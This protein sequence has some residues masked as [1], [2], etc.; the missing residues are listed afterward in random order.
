MPVICD[1][2]MAWDHFHGK[3]TGSFLFCY[4][5]FSNSSVYHSTCCFK[6]LRQ[7]ESVLTR[8]SSLYVCPVKEVQGVGLQILVH[9]FTQFLLL[10]F[11]EQCILN[12]IVIAV[13]A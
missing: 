6:T 8:N 3:G 1:G 5:F 7:T 13:E 10:Y 12:T 9:G 4:L 11:C 2:I